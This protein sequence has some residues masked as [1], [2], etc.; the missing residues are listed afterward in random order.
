MTSHDC[1]AGPH[2]DERIDVAVE[3]IGFRKNVEH[4]MDH[5]VGLE[6][7]HE[8][9]CV[10]SRVAG[11]DHA[12]IDRSAEVIGHDRDA[13]SRRAVVGAGIKGNDE[14]PRPLVHVDGDVLRDDFL[15]ERYEAFGDASQHHA[16]IAGR[17]DMLQLENDVGRG[18][19]ARAHRG[20]EKVLLGPRMPQNRGRSD[21][22]LAR[23]VGERCRVEPF[24]REDAPC[25]VQQLLPGNACR[26]AH[27]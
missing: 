9:Q 15:D 11:P 26:P 23:D 20:P 12:G 18:G 21:A 8:E 16:R 3:R 5:H 27:L 4:A 17:I 25:G 13:P 14:R 19:D 7:S 22:K 6:R 1:A 24:R 2:L 10:G